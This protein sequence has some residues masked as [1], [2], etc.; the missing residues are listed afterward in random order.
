MENSKL[1]EIL[2]KLDVSEIERLKT[3]MVS[4]YFIKQQSLSTFGSLILQEYPLFQT[5]KVN[6][7]NLY[8]AVFPGQKF[9]NQ[10][11]Y[12]LMTLMVTA[13]NQFLAVENFLED[14]IDEK[15]RMLRKLRKMDAGKEFLRISNKL[16]K[17][18]GNGYK[19]H[20]YYLNLMRYE[21]ELDNY[22]ILS[23]GHLGYSP[24]LQNGADSLDLYYLS[25]KLKLACDMMN[26]QNVFASKYEIS[27]LEEILAYLKENHQKIENAPA[28]GIY[29]R[30]ILTLV[31]PEDEVHFYELKSLLEEATF[32]FPAEELREMFNFAQNYCIK[33]INSGRL[34]YLEELFMLYRKMLDTGIIYEHGFISQWDYKN[35][36]STGLRL[37]EFDWTEKFIQMNKDRI[38][39]N[40]RD[41]AYAYNL[42]NYYFEKKEFKNALRT[43][44]LFNNA[45]KQI[46]DPEFVDIFYSLDTRIILLKIYFELEDIEPFHASIDSLKLFLIRNKKVAEQQRINYLNFIKYTKKIDSERQKLQLNSSRGN[47]PF[48]KL[49]ERIISE[50]NIA[51]LTWLQNQIEKLEKE[52]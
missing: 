48:L 29:Y 1:I 33:K 15:L 4:P 12:D 25:S 7:K 51:N 26:R 21:N 23:K 6:E 36:T 46:G 3:F 38:H 8:E 30:I 10:T 43:L 50:K 14:G 19:D 5:D 27:L 40:F 39:P 31:K 22:F 18:L 47:K 44:N 13:I 52:I 16:L 11:I 28:I 35:I 34:Q 24:N 45:L 9:Q 37:N 32:K 20:E 42:A 49:K 41:I 2:K 17:S